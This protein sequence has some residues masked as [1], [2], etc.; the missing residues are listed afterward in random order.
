M[1][2][3]TPEKPSAIWTDEAKVCSTTSIYVA[4]WANEDAIFIVSIPFENCCA[5]QG[6]WSL[7]QMGQDK[8]PWKNCQ[9]PAEHVDQD[10]QADC[11]FRGARQEWRANAKKA[12][13]A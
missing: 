9:V 6:R 1:N 5:A 4:D 10:Q 3:E 7:H 8:S 12:R 11:R 13:S 2:P